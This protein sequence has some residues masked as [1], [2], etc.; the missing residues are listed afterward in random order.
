M[1]PRQQDKKRPTA[2]KDASDRTPAKGPVK[3]VGEQATRMVILLSHLASTRQIARL[4]VER[5]PLQAT[6]VIA[7]SRGH[8]GPT[9]AGFSDRFK[10]GGIY[11][12]CLDLHYASSRRVVVEESRFLMGHL[13]AFSSRLVDALRP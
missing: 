5:V 13:A 9:E 10:E 6:K 3:S 8:S 7:K 11:A 4:V 2:M 12:R 1:R